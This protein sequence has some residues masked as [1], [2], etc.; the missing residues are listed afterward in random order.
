MVRPCKASFLACVSAGMLI[1]S[2]TGETI[3]IRLLL[4]GFELTPT[5]RE[6]NNMFSMRYYLSL[7]LIDEDN[8]RCF[9]QHVC[10]FHNIH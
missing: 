1:F 4:G 9:K 3:P 7:V 10:I 2:S 5:F 6:V 8:R